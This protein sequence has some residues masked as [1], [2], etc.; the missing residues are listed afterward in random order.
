MA[1]KDAILDF[2]SVGVVDGPEGHASGSS[3][4]PRGAT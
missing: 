4:S 1:L 2:H 3:S